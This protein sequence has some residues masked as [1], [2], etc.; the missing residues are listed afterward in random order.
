ML[1]VHQMCLPSFGRVVENN[2]VSNAN[3]FA[4]GY[5]MEIRNQ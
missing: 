2:R 3:I 5:K 1:E 4:V